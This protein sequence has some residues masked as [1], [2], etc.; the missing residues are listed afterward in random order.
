MEP[1]RWADVC[2]QGQFLL[3]VE[4]LSRHTHPGEGR[5]RPT[6]IANTACVYTQSPAYLNEI[7]FQFPWVHFY[8]FRHTEA[9][10]EY[11]PAQPAL[12]S[13][14]AGPTIQTD[15]NKTTSSLEFT[16]ESAVALSR[17]KEDNPDT[18]SAVLICHG[19]SL[20]QQLVYHVL[21]R[22]D[23][24]MLDI[25]GPIPTEYLDGDIVL[26]IQIARN[27]VFACMVAHKTC[28]PTTYNPE[29]YLEEMC[30]SHPAAPHDMIDMH[31]KYGSYCRLLPVHATRERGIRHIQ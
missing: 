12:V 3:D 9:E 4:F 20:V 29:L 11:D 5:V 25:Q 10:S 19:E 27:K 22:A 24:S 7:A 13:A 16:K 17:V 15:R 14:S 26:P 8:A 30:K 18:H 31:P 1:G 28:R 6:V 21:M 23:Y 2:E